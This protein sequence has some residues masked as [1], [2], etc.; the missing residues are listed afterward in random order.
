MTFFNGMRLP[1]QGPTQP[2]GKRSSLLVFF[3]EILP[4]KIAC[5]QVRWWK[6]GDEIPYCMYVIFV[7]NLTFVLYLTNI[8]LLYEELRKGTSTLT[9]KSV[10]LIL[11]YYCSCCIVC[12]LGSMHLQ[13]TVLYKNIAACCMI[14][15]SQL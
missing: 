11:Q 6:K 3:N 4:M 8:L 7:F 15:P 5:G 2:R 10:I 13:H 9:T 1:K 14:L 12:T